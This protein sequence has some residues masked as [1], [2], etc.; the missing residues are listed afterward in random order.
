[1][2]KL[3][4]ITIALFT[5]SFQTIA[6]AKTVDNGV[7]DDSVSNY[8]SNNSSKVSWHYVNDFKV[9]SFIKDGYRMKAYYDEQGELF[10]TTRILKSKDELPKG[11][12]ENIEKNIL[13]GV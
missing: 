4:I 12:I 3:L 8:I 13:V 9:A 1:M 6:N 11:A 2:K 7:I 5:F 10:T